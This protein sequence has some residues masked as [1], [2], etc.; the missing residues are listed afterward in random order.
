M[1]RSTLVLQV[2]DVVASET[3]YCGKLG[4]ISHGRWGDGPEFAIFQRG[5]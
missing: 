1:L 3:F 4:F 5:K 2:T